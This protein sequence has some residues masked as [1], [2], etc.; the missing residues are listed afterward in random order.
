MN[1]PAPFTAVGVTVRAVACRVAPV[2]LLV[3]LALVSLSLATSSASASVGAT[4]TRLPASAPVQPAGESQPEE[5]DTELTASGRAG[6]AAQRSCARSHD[7]GRSLAPGVRPRPCPGAAR[8]PPYHPRAGAP[9]R[10]PLPLR[11]VRCV[12]LRC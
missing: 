4:G 6:R 9:A 8:P 12:V 1:Q 11:A 10:L 5:T 3:L 2:V 7:R